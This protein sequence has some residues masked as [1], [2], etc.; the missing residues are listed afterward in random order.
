MR[1]ES[2]RISVKPCLMMAAL[3]LLPYPSPSH[4]PAASATTFLS[5]PLISA[6]SVSGVI[7]TRNRLELNSCLKSTAF[8]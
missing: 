6:P 8:S 2:A 7:V 3:V 4:K 5:V 1:L